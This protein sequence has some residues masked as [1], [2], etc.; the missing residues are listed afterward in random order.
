MYDARMN[1]TTSKHMH[2]KCPICGKSNSQQP[3][4]VYSRDHW[5]IRTCVNCGFVYLENPPVYEALSEDFAWEKTY[6]EEIERRREQEPTRYWLSTKVKRLRRHYF[7]RNKLLTL[8]NRFLPSGRILDVGCGS[9]DQLITLFEGRFEPYGIEIS[10]NLANTA[11]HLFK[12]HGGHCVHDNAVAGMHHFDENFF[13]GVLMKSYLEHEA[14]PREVTEGAFYCLKPGG[15]LI[16]KVPNFSSINR[17]RRGD[18]W[19]GFRFPDHVNYFTPPSLKNL[20]IDIG[21]EIEKFNFLDHI[22]ISDSMWMVAR[23]PL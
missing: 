11:D 20:V 10:A 3:P 9:G 12:E 14:R 6:W 1:S 22:P 18:R 4:S 15:H 13:D 2:R 19:C 16:I 8:A 23:K 7:R 17:K 21:F 5:Q